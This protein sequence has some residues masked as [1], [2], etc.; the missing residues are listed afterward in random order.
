MLFDSSDKLLMRIKGS[1]NRLYKA[2]IPTDE[3]VCLLTSTT[4][5]AWLWH[6]RLGHVNFQSMKQL[7]EK[8]MAIGVPRVSQPEKVCQGCMTAK[9]VREPFSK[10]ASRRAGDHLN[11][12][13]Q[14]Y[15]VPSALRHQPETSIFCWL[16]M[17]SH[18]G[19]G[20]KWSKPRIKYT[21]HSGGLNFEQRMQVVLE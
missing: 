18:G 12:Y 9:Q 3:S 2:N 19:C 6:Y 10:V 17:I 20:S 14:I 4:D 16:W 7:T 21:R 5:E 13:M 11:W 15:A 1:S 8:E